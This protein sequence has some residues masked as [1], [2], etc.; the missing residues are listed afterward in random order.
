M[1]FVIA[2]PEFLTEAASGLSDIGSSIEAANAAAAA[3]TAAVLAAGTDEVSKAIAAVFAAHAKEYQSLSAQVASFH[4]QFVGVMN[5][6]AAQYAMTEAA[7]VSPLQNLEQQL[8]GAINTL[9]Q[10][11]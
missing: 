8:L 2:A 9:T 6:G 5:A 1:S 11:L 10:L 3:P 4:N 7:N